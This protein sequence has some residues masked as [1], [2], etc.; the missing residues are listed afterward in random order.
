VSRN[1]SWSAVRVHI[2]KEK[3]L[4]SF[5][6]LS[7][8]RSGISSMWHLP[9]F[10]P[11]V[12]PHIR[13]FMAAYPSVGGRISVRWWSHIRPL[14]VAYPSTYDRVSV[15]LRSQF[16]L[17]DDRSFPPLIIAVSPN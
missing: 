10:A 11:Q 12:R 5:S 17:T 6:R 9:C 4:E 3:E 15:H 2:P 7:I 8:E 16:P 13:P 14:V 1:Q